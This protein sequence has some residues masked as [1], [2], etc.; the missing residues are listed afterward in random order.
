MPWSL[1]ALA[2]ALTQ[3]TE[4]SST[5][6]T[7]VVSDI[8]RLA[9]TRIVRETNLPA[10][11]VTVTGTFSSGTNTITLPTDVSSFRQIRLTTISGPGHLLQ[12]HE[13]FLDEYWPNTSN[14][15]EPKYYAFKDVTTLKVA[16]NPDSG[17]TYNISYKSHPT[18]LS[19]AS[20]G[21]WL[22]NHADDVLLYACI[23]ESLMYQKNYL[24]ADISKQEIDYWEERYQRALADFRKE[25]EGQGYTAEYRV[26][27]RI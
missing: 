23:V 7:A 11:N 20:D 12:R 27:D 26:G 10:F 2:S 16:P 25:Y 18:K 6:F 8:V 19:G 14:T 15:A 21:T 22:S 17:Y 13:A 5:D 4:N 24:R 1:S 9:E 3:W